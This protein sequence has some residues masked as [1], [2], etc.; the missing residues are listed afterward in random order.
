[1][2]NVWLIPP[3]KKKSRKRK[4]IKNHAETEKK[5]IGDMIFC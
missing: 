4:L 5:P 3:N 2:K 1:M